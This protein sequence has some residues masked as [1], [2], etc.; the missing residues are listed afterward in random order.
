M[1]HKYARSI[2][3]RLAADA[4]PD[5]QRFVRQWCPPPGGGPAVARVGRSRAA[6]GTPQAQSGFS[7]WPPAMSSTRLVEPRP[8]SEGH[9][10]V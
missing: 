1:L 2:L 10:V 3:D 7:T 9:Q 5:L 8:G 4:V 6:Q